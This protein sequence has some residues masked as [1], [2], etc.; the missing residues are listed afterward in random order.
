MQQRELQPHDAA[1]SAR[2]VTGAVL[3]A[4]FLVLGLGIGLSAGQP[5]FGVLIAGGAWL[6]AIAV[7]RIRR[8]R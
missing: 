1:K 6:C 2:F 7:L 5:G 3:L 4:G 8:H